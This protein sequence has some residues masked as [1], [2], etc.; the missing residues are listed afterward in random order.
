MGTG[1]SVEQLETEQKFEAEPGFTLP[2][3][4]GLPGVAAVTAPRRQR[5]TA[6]YFDTAS[7]RLARA[8]VTL[9]R[10]TGGQDAG[11]HLKLPVGGNTRREVRLPPGRPG[12]PVPGG[13]A[14]LVAGWAKDEPLRPVARLQTTRLVRQLTGGDGQLLA[15]VADDRVTAARAAAGGESAWQDPLRWR[16]IEVELAAGG[17]E[18]LAAAAA[19]LTG[20]G[21][22]PARASSKLSRLLGTG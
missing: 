3:L 19:R 1:G 2:R 8:R 21:A 4:D 17:P 7:L 11:W 16:E 14:D 6:I 15:E 13:L 20:A 22:T 12:G 9:R 18:L 5:L 10:R